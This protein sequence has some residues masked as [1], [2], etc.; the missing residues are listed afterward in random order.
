MD[1]ITIGILLIGIAILWSRVSRLQILIQKDEGHFADLIKRVHHLEKQLEELPKTLARLKAL[2]D[3]IR[4]RAAGAAP[5]LI[6]PAVVA[7]VGKPPAAPPA[8][9]PPQPAATPVQ[10]AVIATVQK[11]PAPS[12]IP[13][14]A[15]VPPA[16]SVPPATKIPPPSAPVTPAAAKPPVV[17]APPQLPSHPMQTAK[18]PVAAVPPHPSTPSPAARVSSPASS[19]LFAPAPPHAKPTRQEISQK[20]F[21]IE[22]R[23]GTNWL[24]KI[25]IVILVIGVVFFIALKL[26]TMGPFGK[27]MVGFTASFVLLGGG[28]FLEKK[29]NYRLLGHTVIGGGWALAYFMTYAMY[30]VT[31]ARLLDSQMVDSVLLLA[32]AGAMVA[33]TLRYNSQTVTGLAFILGFTTVAISRET[34]YSLTAGAILAAGLVVICLRRR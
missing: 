8:P 25:G 6:L 3:E 26:R 27:D 33:H 15:P 17:P 12:P 9:A 7:E 18:P 24:S 13:P 19:P 2:E 32:V 31:A 30:H 14:A 4:G 16:S 11:P 20:A 5:A 29:T 28:I 10:P 34:V 22:E 1:L 21:D 23:L